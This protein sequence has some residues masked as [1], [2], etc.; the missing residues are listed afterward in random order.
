LPQLQKVESTDHL[1]S[2]KVTGRHSTRMMATSNKKRPQEYWNLHR[3]DCRNTLTNAHTSS[4][5]HPTCHIILGSL[6]IRMPEARDFVGSL[7]PYVVGVVYNN[8]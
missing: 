6:N 1:V 7:E 4:R 3:S 5:T 8:F 2:R